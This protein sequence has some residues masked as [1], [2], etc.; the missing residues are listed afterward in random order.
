[1]NTRQYETQNGLQRTFPCALRKSWLNFCPEGLKCS[2]YLKPLYA[3]A[4]SSKITWSRFEVHTI[5]CVWCNWTRVFNSWSR[6][7]TFLFS[8]MLGR[9]YWEKFWFAHVRRHVLRR[10]MLF[11]WYRFA[12]TEWERRS[13][14][15]CHG[16]WFSI[17]ALFS[18]WKLYTIIVSESLLRST[19]YLHQRWGLPP[20]IFQFL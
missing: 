3:E 11:I 20:N 16:S 7:W 18:E 4:C 8:A 12:K 14:E 6:F 13:I 1:M 17:T 5:S 2:C 19:E 10:W 9:N 15:I